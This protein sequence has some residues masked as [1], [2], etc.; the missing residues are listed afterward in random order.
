M[1]RARYPKSSGPLPPP[2]P[3]ATR[4]VGQLVAETIKLY[5][6]NWQAALLI[7]LPAALDSL[8]WIDD[9]I[10]ESQ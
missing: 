10:R 6:A 8:R 4:T 2:L 7:G 5:G 3:P 1:P 9:S